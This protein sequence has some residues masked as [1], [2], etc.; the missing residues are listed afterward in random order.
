MF[1]LAATLHGIATLRHHVI[2]I[3]NVV[4]EN[5]ALTTIW[6]FG[7]FRFAVNGIVGD[8]RRG[9]F[10]FW[11]SELFARSFETLVLFD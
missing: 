5:F 8:A 3:N 7:E 10:G 1:A 11:C 4:R 6:K 2:L 9:S